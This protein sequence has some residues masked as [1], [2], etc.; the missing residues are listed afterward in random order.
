MS[1]ML[2]VQLGTCLDSDD[3]VFLNRDGMSRHLHACGATGS[4]KSVSLNALLRPIM[5]EPSRKATVFVID[6]LGG[7]SRDLMLYMASPKC[8]EHVRKRLLYIDASSDKHVLPFN[9]LQ[10]ATGSAMYYGV[11]R[12]I[13]LILRAWASQD[14]SQMARLMQWS[15]STGTALANA[16]LPLTC[17]EFL[18]HRGTDEHKAF[19]RQMPSSC[20]HDGWKSSTAAGVKVSEFSK[21]LETASSPSLHH[22][23]PAGCSEFLK[24]VLILNNLFESDESS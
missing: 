5:E 8:P 18:L 6:P 20:E 10:S 11:A 2:P 22:H 12:T 1:F 15:Y 3:P 24:G 7:L 9:P 14:L 17:S 19:I 4:G 13:D 21:A 23:I 16:Q